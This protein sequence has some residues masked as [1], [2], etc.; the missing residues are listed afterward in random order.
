MKKGHEKNNRWSYRKEAN[1][2]PWDRKAVR[3]KGREAL[4]KKL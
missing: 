2:K 1:K 3:P 4:I